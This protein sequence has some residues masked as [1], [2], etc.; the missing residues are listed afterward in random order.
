MQVMTLTNEAM[1]EEMNKCKDILAHQLYEAG[2]INE[3]QV[4]Q[5]QEDFAL[6][7]APSSMFGTKVKE[8]LGW[9][10]KS[11]YYKVVQLNNFNKNNK[12][13]EDVHQSEDS[14]SEGV[15]SGD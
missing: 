4:Q 11:T 13:N 9:K 1:T 12:E 8:A 7:I 2:V 15:D 3:E 6:I 14:D 10:D 5:I